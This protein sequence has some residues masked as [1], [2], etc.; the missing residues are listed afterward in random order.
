MNT[1]ECVKVLPFNETEPFLITVVLPVFSLLLQIKL[2]TVK[3]VNSIACKWNSAIFSFIEL[4]SP[5]PPFVCYTHY[6]ITVL[7]L[8][9]IDLFIS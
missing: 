1:L 3:N 6:I 2:Y 8:I 5:S 4:K 9:L 7:F